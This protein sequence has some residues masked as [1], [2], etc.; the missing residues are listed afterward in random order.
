MTKL[1]AALKILFTTEI[2]KIR[3]L[4]FED[5]AETLGVNIAWTDE[6]AALR[7]ASKNY[8]QS[9]LEKIA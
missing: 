5:L 3:E 9:L 1:E 8:L 7:T 2:S 6:W 4:D